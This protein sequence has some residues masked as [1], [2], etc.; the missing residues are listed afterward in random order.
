MSQKLEVWQR[1][2][3]PDITPMLQPVGH[4]LLQAREEIELY[5]HVF[6]ETL[7]WVRLAGLASPGFHLQHLSGV[8][9]RVFTYARGEKLNAFQFEQLDA[10]GKDIPEG[11]TVAALLERFSKQVD[12]AM[13]QL[14]TTDPA[15]L[16]EYR[17]VGRAGLPSTVIGLLVHGAEHTMRHV[18]QLMVTVKVLQHGL[19]K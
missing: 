18:G 8:L 6:P 16:A 15:I 2:P 4:A 1:G 7:L 19:G 9:D 14:R 12:T 10:E 13:E 17:G 5:L 11:L 3:L